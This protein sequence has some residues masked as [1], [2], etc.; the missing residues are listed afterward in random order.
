MRFIFA[1]GHG[2]CLVMSL[3]MRAYLLGKAATPGAG[4]KGRSCRSLSGFNSRPG[5]G[6]EKFP[7]SG[8]MLVSSIP[9]RHYQDILLHLVPRKWCQSQ[10]NGENGLIH[11]KLRSAVCV[12]KWVSSNYRLPPDISL[13]GFVLFAGVKKATI[14]FRSIIPVALYL[15]LKGGSFES[16]HNYLVL[17]IYLSW[18]VSALAL[19]HLQVIRYTGRFVMFSVISNNY[20]KKPKDLP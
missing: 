7:P 9:Y 12:W 14:T 8:T 15:Q 19:G 6:G 1:P 4:I 5:R 20:K 2:C 11:L 3:R 13:T 16:K 17:F 10:R 18:H